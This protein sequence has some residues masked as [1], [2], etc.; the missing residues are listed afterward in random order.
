MRPRV[1][2]SLYSISKRW[3][4]LTD[5]VLCSSSSTDGKPSSHEKA[6]E[7]LAGAI[8]AFVDREVETKG[9]NYIDKEKAKRD[10]QSI[11][12]STIFDRYRSRL[13]VT[14]R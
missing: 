2:S 1:S 3:N 8:G 5:V 7:L 12:P 6:K 9:R 11:H 10:G 14:T 13:N 4:Q